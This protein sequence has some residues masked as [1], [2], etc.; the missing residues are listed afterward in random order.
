MPLSCRLLGGVSDTVALYAVRRDPGTLPVFRRAPTSLEPGV[1][2]GLE[3]EKVGSN[4]LRRSLVA[5]GGLENAEWH[6]DDLL[7]HRLTE[8]I[9]DHSKRHDDAQRSQREHLKPHS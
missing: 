3:P 8:E 6:V 9:A 4:P 2:R 5:A 1:T 7:A